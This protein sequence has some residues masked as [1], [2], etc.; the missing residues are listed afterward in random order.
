MS[1]TLKSTK[2]ENPPLGFSKPMRLPVKFGDS[3]RLILTNLNKYRGPE[4]QIS[5]LYNEYGQEI[6]AQFIINE[7][8]TLYI[9]KKN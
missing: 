2:T 3:V 4:S 8:T 6:P 1:L 5:K 9:D 7:T